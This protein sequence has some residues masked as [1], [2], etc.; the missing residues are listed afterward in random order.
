MIAALSERSG[1]V[2]IGVFQALSA[3]NVG[4]PAIVGVPDVPS[5]TAGLVAVAARSIGGGAAKTVAAATAAATTAT[6][7][8]T[9][10]GCR[11]PVRNR[12]VHMVT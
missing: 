11:R 2:A 1:A 6:P 5:R 3:G 10:R 4:Q 12:C 7:A 9:A 8:S